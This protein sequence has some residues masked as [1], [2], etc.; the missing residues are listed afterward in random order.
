MTFV[1]CKIRRKQLIDEQI[2]L[3]RLLDAPAPAQFYVVRGET[4]EAVLQREEALK[5]RLEPLIEKKSSAAIKPCRTGCRRC[6]AQETHRQLIEQRLLNNDG[7]L[8]DLAARIGADGSW[9]TATRDRLLASAEKLTP[10]DFL[11]ASASQPCAISG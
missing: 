10:D 3:S 7:A 5:Q 9:I 11:K 2:K 4:A 1:Y 8:A 6:A